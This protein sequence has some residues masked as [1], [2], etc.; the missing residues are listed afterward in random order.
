MIKIEVNNK[1][2]HFSQTTSL[3]EILALLQIAQSGI[4]IAVNQN[5]I[6][7]DNWTATLLNN[8]DKVLIIKAT[9]GG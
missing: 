7:N 3:H 6:S 4:A 8:N 1:E 2:H 5:I 9:Q